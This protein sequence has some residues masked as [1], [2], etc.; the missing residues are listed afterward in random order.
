[1]MGLPIDRLVVATMK[2]DVLDEFFRTQYRSELKKHGI[3]ANPMDISK[4]SNYAVYDLF[5]RT[6][7]INGFRQI[8]TK[9]FFG[10]VRS[11]RQ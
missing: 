4:A 2:M 9:G 11:I 8:E 1:M 10:F 7:S 5:A 6:V 3:R